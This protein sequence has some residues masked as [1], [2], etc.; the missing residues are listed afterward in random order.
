MIGAAIGA[1]AGLASSIIGGIGASKAR[2]K[3]NKILDKQEKDNEAWY[4]RK[5]NEDYTQ[6]AEAQAALSRAREMTNDLYKRAAGASAVSGATDESVA[7][8]K[9]ANNAAIADTATNIAA[10]GT[11]QK[12]AVESQYLNTK[13]NLANQRISIYNQQA[14]SNAQAGS[15]G[16]SAGMGVI[17][18]DM[19]SYLRNGKGLFES[20]FGKKEDEAA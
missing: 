18:A 17:G 4:L 3:A 20:L 12:N 9:A 7:Q 8:Q 1:A 5:S 2:K 16:M 15:A 14:A 11:A 10:Q 13:S 19:K 6:S